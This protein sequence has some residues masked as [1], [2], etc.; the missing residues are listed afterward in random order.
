ML[1]ALSD[2]QTDTE[3]PVSSNMTFYQN[4]DFPDNL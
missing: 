4:L 2:G 1:V 3:R